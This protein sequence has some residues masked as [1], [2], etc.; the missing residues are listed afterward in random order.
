MKKIGILGGTFNPPH[1]GHL[2][3]A[4]EVL[5]TLNLDEVRFMP[6]F[7]PPHKESSEE[8][9]AKDRLAML[10]R[11][12]SEHPSF[13]LEKLEIERQGISYTYDSMK[14]LTEKEPDASFYFIIGADMIEYLPNW[15]RI[16]DLLKLVH[17]VGVNRP[18][19]TIKTPYPIIMVDVPEMYISSSTIRRKLR[20]GRTVKYLI[21]DSVVNYIKGNDLYESK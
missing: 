20:T 3:I 21:P 2:I 14:Y 16:D 5:D 10:E 18:G 1:I 4:N 15:Y 12:L 13:S 19:F 7:V 17:F 9:S 6:N 11:A 8:V